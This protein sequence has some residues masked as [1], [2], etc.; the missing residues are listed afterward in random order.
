M[1]TQTF[2]HDSISLATNLSELMESSKKQ[3]IVAPKPCKLVKRAC[4]PAPRI[5]EFCSWHAG[6]SAARAPARPESRTTRRS[7]AL[8][9]RSGGG[10][11]QLK[12]L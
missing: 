4:P 5:T 11:R 7:M 12:H 2:V 8:G 3:P 1:E 6:Q 9:W 10:R